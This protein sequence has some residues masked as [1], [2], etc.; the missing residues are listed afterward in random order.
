MHFTY[1][2]TNVTVIYTQSNK[3]TRKCI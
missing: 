3:Y 1:I 2:S